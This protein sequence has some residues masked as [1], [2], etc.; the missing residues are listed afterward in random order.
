MTHF[1]DRRSFLKTVG[2]AFAALNTTCSNFPKTTSKKPNIILCMADDM[3]W[4]DT[5][6]NGHPV[7]KTPNLDKMS[8]EGIRFDRYYAAAPVCSPTRGSCLTGRNPFRYGIYG[9]NKGHLKKEEIT[10]AEVLKTLGYTTGHFGKW[11]LGTLDKSY[12]GKG[13]KRE[14]EKNYSPPDEN[15]FDEWFSTEFAVATW[16]PYDPAN[17]HLS[18]EMG[19]DTRALYWHNGQNIKKELKGDDSKIIMDKAIPFI[20]SAVE[21]EKPFLAVIWFHAPH[22]PVVSGPTYRAMYADQDESKQHYYGCITALDEQM[23]R[24]RHELKH[25]GIEQNTMLWF[26]SDNGPARKGSGG[27]QDPQHRPT[28]FC[29]IFSR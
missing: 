28:G 22:I 26:A 14:P 19:Y 25:L 2:I 3:G 6:Y 4:G 7:L 13:D 18:K 15:G 5:G 17:T 16:D 27:I 21:N 20:Q 11:H 8:R 24:L 1:I 10:L 9:A 12:S 29:R 23:G